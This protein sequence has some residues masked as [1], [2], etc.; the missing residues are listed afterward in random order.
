[1][2]SSNTT[3]GDLISLDD[4]VAKMPP[5]QTNIYYLCVP[6][7]PLAL[8]SPY[9]EG[10]K[11]KGIEVLFLYAGIDD[12]VMQNLVEYQG[13]R[14]SSI[15]SAEVP[16]VADTKPEEAEVT[17]SEKDVED[18]SKWMKSVLVDRV[19]AIRVCSSPAAREKVRGREGAK[20]RERERLNSCTL[21]NSAI[22]N[23]ACNCCGSRI[24]ILPANDEVRRSKQTTKAAQAAFG[25]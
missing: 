25:D 19:S 11:Q 7:R 13:K 18:F 1:M 15:E 17:M 14:L 12:F 10:F 6:S 16:G 2:E 24:C 8:L 4:Y 21:A 9:Y 20:E 23:F 5:D 3:E 22:S